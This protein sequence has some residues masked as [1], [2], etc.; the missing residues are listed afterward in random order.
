MQLLPIT[1]PLILA[2]FFLAVVAACL[3]ELIVGNPPFFGVIGAVLSA[4]LGVWIFVS[5]PWFE[6]S[7]EPR[8]EDLPVI[9][10]VIG[11]VVVSGLFAFL[12]K[13]RSA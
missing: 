2:L 11:G 4:A 12:R 3:A 9:R 6:I 1:L 7:Y 13:K 10:A 5:L 8:L